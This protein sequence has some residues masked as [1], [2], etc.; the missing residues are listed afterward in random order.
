MKIIDSNFNE[1]SSNTSKY[2]DT[3]NSI[4]NYLDGV[5]SDDAVKSDVMGK[6]NIFIQETNG[7]EFSIRMSNGS[8]RRNK[9]PSS[10]G[11]LK[12]NMLIDANDEEIRIIPGVALR[13]N[14]T[15]HQLVHELLHALSSNE[16]NYFNND[17]TY[18]KTGTDISFYDRNLDDYYMDNNPSSEGLNEG[19]TELL[20]SQIT[21]E[22]TGNYA[23]LVVI[24]NLLSTSNN[25]LIDAYFSKD[26]RLLEEFYNDLEEKQSIISREDLISLKSKNRD[27][28]LTA[29]II[30]GSIE[31]SKACNTYNEELCNNMMSYLDNHYM[32]DYGS[33]SD[34][35][36][37]NKTI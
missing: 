35:I 30:A 26:S 22:Y 12:T 16:H 14:Y 17:I 24:A 5:I 29:R 1:I 4:I 32:L 23:N 18:T 3:Y 8:I 11:A 7:D 21:G 20:A 13:P 27:D 31:Y 37:N 2:Y 6:T 33:W 9:L 34:M 15:D 19:I 36:V 25:S 10:T 28:E